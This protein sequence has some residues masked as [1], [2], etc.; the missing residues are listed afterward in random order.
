M[1]KKIG[2]I[3]KFYKIHRNLGFPQ[4]PHF[5]PIWFVFSGTLGFLRTPFHFCTKVCNFFF[6]KF[7]NTKFCIFLIFTFLNQ[8]G[9][10]F[11]VTWGFC[12]CPFHFCNKIGKILKFYK[13]YNFSFPIYNASCGGSAKRDHRNI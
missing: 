6:F 8:F 1:Q 7:H 4:L 5:Q 9:S 2:K 3:L 10:F 11:R 13:I 12:G